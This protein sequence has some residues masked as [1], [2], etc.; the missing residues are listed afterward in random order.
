M[1]VNLNENKLRK[2]EVEAFKNG[3][4]LHFDAIKLFEN[5]SY[6]SA[7]ALS[8]LSLEEFGK[9]RLIDEILF[10]YIEHKGEFENDKQ[11]TDFCKDFENGMLSHSL[12][13]GFA[14]SDDFPF[15]RGRNRMQR[16]FLYK[17]FNHK[18]GRKLIDGWKMRS[19][20]VGFEHNSLKGRIQT[21]LSFIKRKKAQDQITAINDY[22][23]NFIIYLRQGRW[24]LD[25][26]NLMRFYNT[27]LLNKLVDIWKNRHEDTRS[28]LDT[29]L[30]SRK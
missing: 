5:K 20:Y 29:F 21:P 30:S 26:E 10:R 28:R 4:R 2:A 3:I 17:M 13:Q 24:T 25:N 22:L 16:G 6:P 15:M 27:N 23:V 11:F 9:Q 14:V 12:K 8:V 7:Y 18:N 1:G 19:I